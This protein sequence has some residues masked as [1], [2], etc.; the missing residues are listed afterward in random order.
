MCV[1]GFKVYEYE[2]ITSIYSQR[3]YVTYIIVYT[4]SLSLMNALKIPWP[5]FPPSSDREHE[6]RRRLLTYTR[7][8]MF[9]KRQQQQQ[10]LLRLCALGFVF[11]LMGVRPQETTNS[12][13]SSPMLTELRRGWRKEIT[14]LELP[15]ARM[16]FSWTDRDNWKSV[17]GRVTETRQRGSNEV[18]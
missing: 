13:V 16:D 5:V 15:S 18:P 3:L 8:V 11:G 1:K 6:R 7:R 17:L 4:H 9:P 2:Q 10:H 14:D 12:D